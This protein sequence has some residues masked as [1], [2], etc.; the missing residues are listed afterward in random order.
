MKKTYLFL[1]TAVITL[2]FL[3]GRVTPSMARP[4]DAGASLTGVV[5]FDGVAPKPAR[6]DMSADP[7]C[8]KA[9]STAASTEENT[10]FGFVF[11]HCKITAADDPQIKTY[12]GRPWRA[13]ASAT[14]LNCEL[15]DAIRP[16]GWQNWGRP[17]REK[18]AR[19][20][21]FNSTGP[22]SKTTERVAWSKQLSDDE[23]KRITAEQV[24]GDWK[25]T[26]S[27]IPRD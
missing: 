16:E 11:S 15:P 22:G 8:A 1:L 2:P 9:H 14:F 21:E 23:A 25:A 19:Y 10:P 5:K 20:S 24:F 13:F 3:F 27:P 12:L 26:E 17:E 18:T 4:A 6:I 7:N